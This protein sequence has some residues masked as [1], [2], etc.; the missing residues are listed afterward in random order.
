LAG[1]NNYLLYVRKIQTVKE[2]MHHDPDL[3]TVNMQMEIN[4]T[5]RSKF[6]RK[7]LFFNKEILRMDYIVVQVGDELKFTFGLKRP[8]AEEYTG[9]S[10]V[11]YTVT[12]QGLE[13]M[14]VPGKNE[15][16]SLVP[17]TTWR[18]A[19]TNIPVHFTKEMQYSTDL[20]IS[21][22]ENKGNTLKGTLLTGTSTDILPSVN[23]EF[24]IRTSDFVRLATAK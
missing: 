17:L 3:D 23:I 4:N 11:T 18:A 16:D 5:T 10:T 15:K 19:S 21:S 6:L 20:A 14:I 7:R 2:T 9:F 24:E 22:A 1:G 13:R 8:S 12:T